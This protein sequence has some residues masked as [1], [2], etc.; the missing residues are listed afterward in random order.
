MR[1]RLGAIVDRVRSSFFFVPTLYVASGVLLAEFGVAFDEA[2]GAID[3][4]LR[5]SSTVASARLV[6]SVVAGAT[7]SFAGIAFSVSLLIISMTSSQYSPRVVHGLFR[8]PYNKRAIG[9]VVGT[10]AYCLAVIRLVRG[11]LEEGGTPVIPSLSV[12]LAVVFGLVAIL[13]IVAFINHSAHSMDISRILHRITAETIAMSKKVWTDEPESQPTEPGA[14]PSEEG[15]VV[16]LGANGWIQQ[17][18]LDGLVG[19]ASDGG[20]IRV[21]TYVGRYAIEGSPLCT[22]W[23]DPENPESTTRRARA[24]VEIGESRT[25]QQD[26][27]YGLRQLVDIALKALSPGINDPTTAQDAIFHIGSTV[28][29]LLERRPR[30]ISGE[31]E[32][33]TKVITPHEV[34]HDRIL[35][36]AFDEIRLAAV[37][38]PAVSIYLL[39]VIHQIMSVRIQRPVGNTTQMLRHQADLVLAGVKAEGFLDA[40]RERVEQTHLRLFGA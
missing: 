22:L 6:L 40:D 10:F 31:G 23:P 4:P 16:T 20:T 12:G 11:P 15:F 29:A 18:D 38:Q 7:I 5:L 14:V 35:S 2:I 28:E 27:T 37:G 1:V 17:L 19:L 8:D 39:E 9:I 34:S 13:S 25:M 30:R 36:L 26:V 21:D 3:L 32:E 33:G 24:A